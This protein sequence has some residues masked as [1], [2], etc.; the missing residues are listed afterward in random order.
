MSQVKVLR[1]YPPT[2]KN[3]FIR[4]VTEEWPEQLLDN[5]AQNMTR[6][7]ECC[8]NRTPRWACP[9]LRHL[10]QRY[11][12]SLLC[13]FPISTYTASNGH[14]FLPDVSKSSAFSRTINYLYSNVRT[15]W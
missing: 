7:A 9:V 6:R 1:E 8:M 10:S 13:I 15:V 14:F 2:N 3:T 11:I 12:F 4:V 5:V